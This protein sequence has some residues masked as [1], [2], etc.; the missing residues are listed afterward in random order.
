LLSSKSSV[1]QITKY[2]SH[3]SHFFFQEGIDPNAFAELMLISGLVLM[4]NVKW[5]SFHSG[6][7]FGYL[8]IKI[9]KQI[10][11]ICKFSRF[12]SLAEHGNK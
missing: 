6:Y 2:F 1:S 10:F 3:S 5:L 12:S 9:V 4:D 7:D 8:V 11:E